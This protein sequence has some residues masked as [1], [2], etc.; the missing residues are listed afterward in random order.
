MTSLPVTTVSVPGPDT[1]W[2]PAAARRL[3]ISS[4]PDLASYDLPTNLVIATQP[5]TSV[6]AG[7]TLGLTVDVEDRLGDLITGYNGSVT[8]ALANNPGSGT[9]GGTLTA[10]VADGVATFSDLTLVTAGIGY[11]LQVSG[12]T[13]MD[14]T[15]ILH[16]VSAAAASQLVIATRR[17][18]RRRRPA[19][20]SAPSR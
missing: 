17:P 14:A 1:T 8:V 11:T 12:G 10:T 9:L 18:P 2:S 7:D 16:L 3:R 5:S 4:I 19:R 13:L 15:S 6:T 20:R